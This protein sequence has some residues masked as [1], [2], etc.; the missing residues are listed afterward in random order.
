MSDQLYYIQDSRQFVG[1]CVLFWR[2]GGNG[3]TTDLSEAQIY[4][5]EDA[6]KICNN[7]S[8]DK[9]W[10]IEQINILASETVDMQR[11]PK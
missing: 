7:R 11:L 10:P 1:N 9:M 3:Y 5:H 8:T 6:T 2:K 4:T